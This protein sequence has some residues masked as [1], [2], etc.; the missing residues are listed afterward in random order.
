LKKFLKTDFEKKR[1]KSGLRWS[2]GLQIISKII[3]VILERPEV[4]LGLLKCK[5]TIRIAL[6]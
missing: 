2:V 1:P 3:E 6:F 5:I 4:A